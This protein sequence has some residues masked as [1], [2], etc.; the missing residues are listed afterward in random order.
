MHSP[1]GQSHPDCARKSAR[2]QLMHTTNVKFSKWM[3]ASID[4]FS[5]YNDKTVNEEAIHSTCKLASQRSSDQPKISHQLS[6]HRETALTII[7]CKPLPQ[8]RAHPDTHTQTR[9]RTRTRTRT[10][11]HITT[12]TTTQCKLQ[13]APVFMSRWASWHG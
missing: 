7:T 5:G 3:L 8:R 2:V 13:C 12:T 10:H 4:N 9:T 6:C 11:T 1:R